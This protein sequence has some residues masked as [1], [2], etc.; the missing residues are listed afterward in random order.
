VAT[1]NFN[2]RRGGIL[3]QDGF[4]EN[5]QARA[6][7]FN[8][9]QRGFAPPANAEELLELMAL[10]LHRTGVDGNPSALGGV[11]GVAPTA[12]VN[13]GVRH[14]D[15]SSP[16]LSPV[17]DSETGGRE[18]GGLEAFPPASPPMSLRAEGVPGDSK[19]VADPS[20]PLLTGPGMGGLR[21]S[22]AP[23]STVTEGAR[24]KFE[25]SLPSTHSS[26]PSTPH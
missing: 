26:I 19:P 17:R 4:R 12:L 23:T 7:M 15:M 24:V 2:R 13:P 25:G 16:D 10:L 22:G 5:P 11:S 14:V 9:Q 3:D 21:G 18:E 6:L 8:L 20:I 1:Q